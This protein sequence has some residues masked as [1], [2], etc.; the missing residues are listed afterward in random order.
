[1]PQ[2]CGAPPARPSPRLRGVLRPAGGRLRLRPARAASPAQTIEAGPQP[3]LAL[4]RAAAGAGR[5]R[6]RVSLG[7]GLD[8]A[9]AGRTGSPRELG[10]TAAVGQGRLRQPDPLVQGPRRRGRPR[11]R[12]RASAST[13]V[14]LR[15]HRQPGQRG[16]RRTPPAPACARCVFIPHDLEQGKI[17]TTAVYGGDT[18]GDQ[19]NYDDVN[20]LC[21]EIARQ[22]SGLGLRQRQPAAVLRG[23]L[24]DARVTRSPSSSAGG[25]RSRSSCRSPPARM[26]TKVDKAFRELR[27]A[28][29]DRRSD[30]A[31]SSGPRRPGCSPVVARLCTAGHDVVRPCKP[32][33][34]A[35]SLAI[36]N[37]ADGPYVAGRRPPHR[38]GDARRDRRGRSWRASGCSPDRGGLRRDGR[39]GHRRHPAALLRERRIDPGRRDRAAQHRR[40]PED[41]RRGGRTSGLDGH[42]PP[43]LGR[44]RGRPHTSVPGRS[45]SPGSAAAARTAMR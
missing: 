18:G 11:R 13:T 24:Q 1:M 14:V 7:A 30:A 17:V 19:G 34:I 12:A 4:R 41:H 27:E 16:R 9:G 33:T 37:P 28:G 10:V 15:L 36:G 29:A 6:T 38:R 45:A 23:G 2:L 3:T 42:I 5:R 26:L 21:T 39:R 31:R 8:P 40:R 35:K 43:N 32:N 25:C 22:V 20:R 44:V